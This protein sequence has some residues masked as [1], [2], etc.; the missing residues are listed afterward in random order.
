MERRTMVG[1]MLASEA[2][3][4]QWSL[5]SLQRALAASPV[6]AART[7]GAAGEV[8]VRRRNAVDD[9]YELWTG[10]RATMRGTRA[11]IIEIAAHLSPARGWE[12]VTDGDDDEVAG[13]EARP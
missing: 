1:M 11:E 4:G 6:E 10:G 2:G 9:T 12:S 5:P 8:I 13:S 3:G 7:L